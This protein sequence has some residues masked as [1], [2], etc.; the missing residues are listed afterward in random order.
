MTD[1]P[2][3]RLLFLA[4]AVTDG[5]PTLCTTHELSLGERSSRPTEYF[6]D[7]LVDPSGR[8]AIVSAYAGKL[9]FLFFKGGTYKDSVD[10]S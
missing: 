8:Y 10:L 4:Y 1:H 2:D 3:P 5:A 6:T 9:K 7:V